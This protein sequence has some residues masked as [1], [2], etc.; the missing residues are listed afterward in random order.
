MKG[1][2]IAFHIDYDDGFVAYLNGQEFAGTI[3]WA[4]HQRLTKEQ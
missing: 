4:A 3:S 2:K 1:K